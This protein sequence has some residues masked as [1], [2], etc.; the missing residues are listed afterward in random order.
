M[1]KAIFILLLFFIFLLSSN[2]YIINA[3]VPIRNYLELLG[4]Y[5]KTTTGLAISPTAFTLEV[6]VK[7]DSVAGIQHIVSIGDKDSESLHYEVG[8]N[9]GS[10]SLNYRYGKGSQK[11]ITAGNLI[12][13]V[14]SHIAVSLSSSSTRL[15]INGSAIFSTSGA[16]QLL[17][18]GDSIVVGGSFLESF[19]GEGIF[20]GEIDELRISSA[21]YDIA[22]LWANGAYQS[23]L[24]VDN[25]TI[26]LWHL[27]ETRGESKAGDSS[28][29]GFHA[30]LIG[31]DSKIHFFG[32]L[33]TPTPFA[34]PTLSWERPI[35]PTLSFPNIRGRPTVTPT[36]S[37][38]NP[39]VFPSPTTG[40]FPRSSR[41]VYP[42]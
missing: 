13:D 38:A 10:L 14:W 26:A 28:G 33:P 5:L 6:W 11:V 23:A 39:T 4:G 8:I 42:R 21:S 22:N 25:N 9:G 12:P 1:K 15:F 36:S 40:R 16:S 3:Q 24:T 30:D 18:I 20:K 31:G 32:I 41:P 35:L 27:D 34:L 2:H 19:W 29:N 7:P 17:P 37:P